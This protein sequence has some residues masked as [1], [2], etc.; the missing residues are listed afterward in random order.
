MPIQ[1]LCPSC[2]QAIEV[3]DIDAG[4]QVACFYCKSIITA[5]RESTLVFEGQQQP[6]QARPI[7]GFAPQQSPS[8]QQPQAPAVE[9]TAAPP[10]GGR[11]LAVLALAFG[12]AC[13]LVIILASIR[14]AAPMF[15]ELRKH[16]DMSPEQ[17]QKLLEK[18]L[19]EQL[20]QEQ[21]PSGVA[22][23]M[24]AVWL[25]AIAGCITAVAA[26]VRRTA[27]RAL[28]WVALLTSAAFFV[29]LFFGLAMMKTGN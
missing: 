11:A 28:A 14:L 23:L 29:I 3:D 25:F 19:Q 24:P 10:A 4:R 15:D 16:P 21:L 12:L 5:P 2:G 9:P 18:M 22:W 1:F 27:Y 13:W 20:E 6:Q 7:P 17:Q 8:A 26:L